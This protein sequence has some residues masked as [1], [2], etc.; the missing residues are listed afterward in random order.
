MDCAMNQLFALLLANPRAVI[1]S[2]VAIPCGLR[3]LL[4]VEDDENVVIE[5]SVDVPPRLRAA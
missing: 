3:S 1:E 2:G 4:D 5:C